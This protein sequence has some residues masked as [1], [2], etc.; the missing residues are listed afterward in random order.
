MTERMG[1]TCMKFAP[2]GRVVTMAAMVA[3][4]AGCGVIGGKKGG[5][6][7]PV[8]GNRTS[9]LNNEQGVEIEPSLADVQVTLPA[10]YVNDSWSQPGGDPSKAMG[11]VSLGGSPAQVWTASIEGSSPQARLAASP[12]VAGGKLF[13]T[14]AGAHVIAFDAASGAKLWQTNL[15]SE[16]KGNGRVL[17]GG[18]VSVL[19]DRVFASTGFG[20][21]FALNGADGAI[22]W[23]KHL[24]GPLRGAP[25]LE[26]GHVYVMGQ[27]NQ[28]FA[29]NQSDGE[30]QW[31][32]SGTL[33]VTG[34]FGV[35]APAAAQ[36]TVIAGYS[37]GEINAY[38]YENGRTLWGD[39][40]SRTSIST[41]VASLTDIDAD[42]VID[43]G[44]V[45]AIGQGGRMASYELTSG[46]R[47]WEINIAGISTPAVVGEWVF[48]VTS[49]ARL[50]CVARATGKIRWVSQLRR[51]QKEKKKDK[52]IRWTGPLL[53]GGRLIV[54]STRGEMVYVDP[55]TGSV[56]ST[57][58]MDRSMSLSPIVANN[59]LYVLADDGKLT[60]F[61]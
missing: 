41:A 52:A 46:Q 45:F 28:V 5:P 21:V 33:Q 31:T 35:A 58:D 49:D 26:N 36:G 50:L 2:I 19:G 61:R 29:L 43:R 1:M 48:A 25:T 44:R 30:T 27:D 54:V 3:L 55:T 8:V 13:V 42:P 38:R 24:S 18:G 22:L 56:Q 32:D 23:K 53:A 12:V 60:A 6:K 11:H 37:S 17:F 47:L 10:P 34:I 14:D 57:V 51:W 39:A 9:I 16:G 4:L 7:T 20:D 15:P 40:L 59:M